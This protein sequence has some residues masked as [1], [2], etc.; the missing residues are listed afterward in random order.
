M[1][2][3]RLVRAVPLI[4]VLVILAV[5]AYFV[6]Q[7]K[8]SPPRAKSMLIQLFTWITGGISGFF[9]LACLYALIEK[10]ITV[11]E[12]FATFLAAGLICLGITRICYAVLVRHYPEYKRKARTTTGTDRFSWLKGKRRR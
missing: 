11:L 10:N 2:V 9:V 6:M 3:V 4:V 1:I 7:F 8:Y 12:L 5:I